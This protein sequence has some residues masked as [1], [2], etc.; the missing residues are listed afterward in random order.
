MRWATWDELLLSALRVGPR[1]HQARASLSHMDTSPAGRRPPPARC[2]PR[3][4]TLPP[5]AVVPS[6]P[7]QTLEAVNIILPAPVV[8][9]QLHYRPLTSSLSSEALITTV[10][11]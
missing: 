3:R 11:N 10:I 4:C 2:S 6:L 9:A 1:H 5:R 8:L 7:S